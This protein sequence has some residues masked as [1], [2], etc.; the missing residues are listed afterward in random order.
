MRF[1]N[2]VVN[3]NRKKVVDEGWVLTVVRLEIAQ[4]QVMNTG[5][6]FHFPMKL[7]ETTFL[8]AGG[9]FSSII[10]F[11]RKFN[12]SDELT[13]S[14]PWDTFLYGQYCLSVSF[15]NV[16]LVDLFADG[17]TLAHSGTQSG[18]FVR[19]RFSS[20]KGFSE[21]W[22]DIWIAPTQKQFPEYI[23]DDRGRLLRA[24]FYHLFLF[25]MTK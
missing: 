3:Y 6:C 8:C 12:Q 22:F 4:T 16:V 24:L 17:C 25:M 18:N 1:Y 13:S 5:G 11:E 7:L 21:K 10:P 14:P 2:Y 23:P 15:G 19:V 20:I 9:T